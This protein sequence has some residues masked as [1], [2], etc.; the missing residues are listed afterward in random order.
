MSSRWKGRGAARVLGLV[1]ALAAVFSV[2]VW[3][4]AALPG[5]IRVARDQSL[6]LGGYLPVPMTVRV[7]PAGILRVSGAESGPGEQ[8]LGLGQPLQIQGL[9]PGRTRLDFRIFGLIPIRRMTVDVVPPLKLVPGGHSIGVVLR[10]RGVLVVGEAGI[11]VAPGTTVYPAREGG[12]QVGDRILRIGNHEA[13]SEALVQKEIEAA[14]RR[15]ESVKV[16]LWRRGREITTQVRPVLDPQSG[17]WR[18]GLYIR[19][20]AAGVG[21]LTFYD[22]GS[23]RY[24]ALGHIIADS[25]T[26]QPIPVRDGHIV[27]A[28]VI[29]IDKGA[30]GQPGEKVGELTGPDRWIGSIEQNTRF[31]IF[32]RLEAPL[33]NPLYPEPI[34]VAMAGQVRKGKA[35]LLTVVGGERLERF[36]VEIVDLARSPGP[37]GRHMVLRVTDPRLLARTRGIVQ[38]MS[39]SPIIQDGRLVGAVTHVFVNDPSRGYGVLIEWMLQE[40]GLLQPPASSGPGA[41]GPGAQNWQNSWPHGVLSAARPLQLAESGV[42][43]G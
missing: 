31:G 30:R 6:H 38:G 7:A 39:G 41:P 3:V 8:R 34:P 27:R 5:H 4:L 2:P 19:D 42:P 23:G 22:P 9:D 43:C 10:S 18:I 35:E 20:G 13:L 1:L 14:G 16:T 17:R 15:G 21:T 24:G 36:E 33:H 29:D 26:G 11:A 28:T 32:G 37:D 25:E 40:A 12:I